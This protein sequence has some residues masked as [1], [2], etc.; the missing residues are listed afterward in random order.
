MEILPLGHASFKLRGKFATVVTDPYDEKEMGVKYPKHIEADILTISHNH[1]D[2]NAKG[3]IGGSPFVVEGAGEYEIKGVSVIGVGSFHDDKN[4]EERGKNTMY[5][6]EID[7]L[8][9]LHLGDLGHVLSSAQVDVVDGVDVLFI[10]VGG[11]YTIDA[12][13]AAQVISDLEPRI[14]IPMHYGTDT[15]NK[16]LAPVSV[17]LK[18]MGKESVTPVSKL[19]I[20]RDK[21][22][23]EM[24]VVVLE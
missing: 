3:L 11:V 19:T 20:S 17:F 6:I 1:F 23:A 2:H 10:P 18:Q 13:K 5:R 14:V 22:P 24:Q 8:R 4:G 15:Y 12:E 9:L 7:G 21:L 16:S